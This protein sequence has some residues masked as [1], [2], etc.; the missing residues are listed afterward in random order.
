MNT[1]FFLIAL[2]LHIISGSIG[3]ISGTVAM[4][5]PK[6]GKL[7]KQAGKL[8]FY[9]MAAIFVSSLYMSIV[10]SNLYLLLIGFFSFYLACTGYRILR[11]KKLALQPIAPAALDY[12]IGFTGIV[13]GACMLSYAAYLL[14]QHNQFG[15]VILCFG[16]LAFWLGYRDL[17]KFRIRPTEKTHWVQSHGLRMAGAYAATITAFVVVNIQIQQQWILWLLPAVIVIPLA[18]RYIN[19]LL[20]PASKK[21]LG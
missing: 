2:V 5:A 1:S 20:Q 9:A 19:R 4:A 18:K 7:H 11:L 15:I 17:R 21:P 3:L 16:S 8:F 10:K 13:S 6:A 12:L 14:L